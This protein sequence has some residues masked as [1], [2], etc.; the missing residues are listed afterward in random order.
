MTSYSPTVYAATEVRLVSRGWTIVPQQL[1]KRT[2]DRAL[3]R[4]IESRLVA[5]I[6]TAKRM[7]PVGGLLSK[8]VVR[9]LI[10]DDEHAATLGRCVISPCEDTSSPRLCYHYKS[11]KQ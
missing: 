2:A 10:V 6:Q 7:T 1:V 8:H 5:A 3:K 9:Q 11:R 4:W